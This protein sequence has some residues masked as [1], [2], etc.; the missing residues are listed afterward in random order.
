M[1]FDNDK[2][3]LYSPNFQ[4]LSKILTS[5]IMTQLISMVGCKYISW[6]T[7]RVLWPY[8]MQY[9]AD[10]YSEG[11]I[12]HLMHIASLCLLWRWVFDTSTIFLLLQG[13]C[14]STVPRLVASL[15]KMK[16]TFV[17]LQHLFCVRHLYF[18]C[19]ILLS[20]LK[21]LFFSLSRRGLPS[22]VVFCGNS[23]EH[24]TRRKISHLLILMGST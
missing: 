9:A 23:V 3:S 2:R 14:A 13:R 8:M 7:R 21:G 18:C 16:K 12:T 10:M 19:W 4:C 11:Q 15:C 5:I 17:W 1:N 6:L 22:N 20:P 24:S